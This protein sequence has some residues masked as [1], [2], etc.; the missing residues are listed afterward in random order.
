MVKNV[1][2]IVLCLT[3]AL[4]ADPAKKYRELIVSQ[5]Q[6]KK[7]RREYNRL[8]VTHLRKTLQYY[9]Q[10]NCSLPQSKCMI[11]NV[12]FNGVHK[13]TCPLPELLRVNRELLALMEFENR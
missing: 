4:F 2:I 1:T 6:T 11:C 3:A 7:L 10:A 9:D 8:L 5:E 13:A 12:C